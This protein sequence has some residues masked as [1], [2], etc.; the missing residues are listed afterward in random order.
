ML[1]TNRS[2]ETNDIPPWMVNLDLNHNIIP[3]KIDTGADVTVISKTTYM[4]MKNK[5]HLVKSKP[6]LYSLSGQIKSEGSFKGTFIHKDC[7]YSSVVHFVNYNSENLLSRSLAVKMQLIARIDSLEQACNN[8]WKVKLTKP[9]DIKLHD[10][11]EP[12]SVKTPRRVAIPLLPKV[13]KELV[14]M[15]QNDIIVSENEPTDWCS[16][17]VPVPKGESDVCIC[18]DLKRL[19]ACVKRERYVLPTIDELVHK[20]RGATVFSSLDAASGYWQFPLAEAASKL[21]TFITPFGRFR[22]KRLPF[23]ISSASEIFQREMTALLEGIEGILIYQDDILV[24]GSSVEEHDKRLNAVLDRII[25]S[26]LQLNKRKYQIRQKSLAFL[27]HIIDKDGCRPHPDKISAISSMSRP[28]NVTEVR[29]F[30]GMIN[31][32]SRYVPNLSN[33]MAPINHLLKKDS[34]WIWD[35]AQENA[36]QE[37]KAAISSPTI[38]A[39]YDP[40]KPTVVQS[41]AS[42]YGIGGVI[43]QDHDG[44]YRP[45]AYASR[46]LTNAETKIEKELLAAVWC[47]EKFE[48]YLMGLES[49]KI[50]TDHKPLIP[51]INDKDIDTTPIRCQRLLLRIMRYN[52]MAQ[53]VPGKLL[54]V[55]DALSRKPNKNTDSTLSDDIASYVHNIQVSRPITD[56]RLSEIKQATENDIELQIVMKYT[57]TVN[58]LKMLLQRHVHIT[59]PEMN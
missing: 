20:L 40:N 32:L 58:V 12:I 46:S 34:N 33:I 54:V 45:V 39:Y 3:F 30:S 49:F 28:E 24:Y 51:I 53:Y 6:S 8:S 5:P 17:I 41:D 14:R 18:V 16:P 37:I 57:L 4:T 29:Q 48:K 31:F 55:A 52:A 15:Q 23:G 11:A 1:A 21:T 26:G 19:N 22:F 38:L 50:A 27:G 9:I 7:K 59:V 25:A 36:F 56:K 44:T 13:K 47:C 42:S 10:N 35:V 2:T 43:L